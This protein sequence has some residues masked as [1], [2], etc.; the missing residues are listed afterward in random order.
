MGAGKFS[1]VTNML[2]LEPNNN[3]GQTQNQKSECKTYS[4]RKPAI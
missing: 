1:E 3:R 2:L 4:S